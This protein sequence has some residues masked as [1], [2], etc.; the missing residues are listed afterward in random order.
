[1]PYIGRSTDGFG[2]RNRFLYLASADDTSVSGA[3]ANGATLTF[4]D[5]AY[6]DV[7]LNGVLLKA[8]TDYNTNTAN[9]IASLSAMSANDEVTVIV[10]DVFTVGDM[11][12]ATSGGTF[13]GAVTTANLT[14][15]SQATSG[16][17]PILKIQR[18]QAD[19]PQNNDPLGQLDFAGKND[20]EEEV[21]YFR[22]RGKIKDA[23][24]G[25]ED[26]QMV[27]KVMTN[28]T[29]T[30][31]I[32]IEG[33]QPIEL[34]GGVDINGGELILDADGDTSITADTDDQIDIKI[35]GTDEVTLSSSGIVI[36]EGG[37]DR[38]FRVESDSYSHQLF[39]DAG[40]NSVCIGGDI[41]AYATG[42]T[43]LVVGNANNEQNGIT[44]VSG[45][46]T[47]NS[48]LNFSDSNSGDGRR[49]GQINYQHQYDEF[50]WY[51]ENLD[52]L[53]RFTSA[54]NFV[55][56]TGYI[57]QC[58]SG[59]S[60]GTFHNG[61]NIGGYNAGTYNEMNHN[62]ADWILLLKNY[63]TSGNQYGM[64]IGHG[65]DTSGT[66][67]KFLQFYNTS[68]TEFEV[69]GNGNV[70]NT[71]NSYGQLSDERLKSDITDAKSQWDD[72]KSIKVRNFKKHNTGDL[73]QI[74]VVAQ[75]LE[76]ISPHL[77]EECNPLSEDIKHDASLG[78]LYTET[79]K[80]NGDIPD[81]RI[82]GDVKEVKEKVKGVKYSVLYMKAVKALQEAMERIETLE[83]KVKALEEA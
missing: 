58:N 22:M 31:R 40:N 65:A 14:V 63:A 32:T 60:G 34:D 47:G 25:S 74:G 81:G 8:G 30:D 49:A 44:I 75:E 42:A 64:Y 6:V 20:A 55:P 54:G 37:N 2:V 80:D 17:Q 38:D 57:K 27:F 13:S 46:G 56:T 71:N 21:N 72:L 28:G 78:T 35:G 16:F 52:H 9:T 70:Q 5:G 3:D 67:S 51:A 48:T 73:V 36:N 59:A 41:A 43:D 19:T 68:G 33:G 12:S 69:F 18:D 79:D 26:G 45:S 50:Q 53:I 76:K 4:T 15:T 23:S 7:Y 82:V 10:Y 61:T 24:D 66:T 77:V 1:M 39:V 29:N 11:V 62:V 83:A